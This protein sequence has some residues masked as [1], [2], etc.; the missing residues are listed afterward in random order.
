MDMID[1]LN[2]EH[3]IT[4][5]DNA[6]LIKYNDKLIRD[7]KK[8]KRDDKRLRKE[9]NELQEDLQTTNDK[10]KNNLR[11]KIEKNI[12]WSKRFDYLSNY[13]GELIKIIQQLEGKG[14]RFCPCT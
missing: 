6:R 7:A 3:D 4:F 10:L 1:K 5:Q 13:N 2:E 9:K 12:E 11:C 14:G 8:L